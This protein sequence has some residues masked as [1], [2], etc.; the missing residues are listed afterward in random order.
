MTVQRSRQRFS[1]LRHRRAIACR[2]AAPTD[3]RSS[4]S[5]N[6]TPSA[7]RNAATV[8]RDGEPRSTRT[9]T[10]AD[11]LARRIRASAGATGIPV[12]SHARVI[13]ACAFES[14]TS[15]VASAMRSHARN[16]TRSI[17][18]SRP[19]LMRSADD[20]TMTTVGHSTTCHPT[21]GLRIL[22]PRRCLELMNLEMLTNGGSVSTARSVST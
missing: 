15:V 12:A 3:S 21:L 16:F 4:C 17:R 22:S 20:A 13:T 10:P 6:N 9:T 11:G 2:R 19:S 14:A 8:A 1:Q 7:T 5:S 18:P